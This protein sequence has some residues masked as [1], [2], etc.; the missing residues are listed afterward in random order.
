MSTRGMNNWRGIVGTEAAKP[1]CTAI[2]KRAPKSD[3]TTR[4]KGTK[5]ATEVK[6][7]KMTTI[8]FIQMA[9]KKAKTIPAKIMYRQWM[10]MQAQVREGLQ[11]GHQQSLVGRR[12]R[13][14][15]EN[16]QFASPVFTLPRHLKKERHTPEDA[17]V[18]LLS[19]QLH[20]FLNALV[21]T[22]AFIFS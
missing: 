3:A 18:S 7:T 16:E 14:F 4:K 21:P 20:L 2:C 19:Q 1:T 12:W 13:T 5:K 8:E 17:V 9:N 22:T 10:P 6:H 15:E 11:E